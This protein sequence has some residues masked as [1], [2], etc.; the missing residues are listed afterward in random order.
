MGMT[1]RQT[2]L[3]VELPLALPVMVAGIRTA[4]VEVIASAT[5]A[6]FIGGGGL[7]LYITR[8]FAMYDNAILLTGAIPVALPG[9]LVRSCCLVWL[10]A[11]GLSRLICAPTAA[12]RRSPLPPPRTATHEFV[13]SLSLP[14]TFPLANHRELAGCV[15][16]WGRQCQTPLLA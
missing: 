9:F 13:I 2:L 3:R 4:T 16:V 10:A 14:G 15:S 5:L 12:P 6:A 11:L 8:G 1:P 7:G